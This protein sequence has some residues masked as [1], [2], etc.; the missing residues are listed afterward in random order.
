MRDMAYGMLSYST[1]LRINVKVIVDN[2]SP[3]FW[4]YEKESVI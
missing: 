3:T 4:I 2:T 1:L